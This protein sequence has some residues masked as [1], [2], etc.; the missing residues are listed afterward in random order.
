VRGAR[1]DQRRHRHGSTR[2]QLTINIF[3]TGPRFARHSQASNSALLGDL[4]EA[5]VEIDKLKDALVSNNALPSDPDSEEKQPDLRVGDLVTV[6]DTLKTKT[7]YA[8]LQRDDCV[9]V[10]KKNP[11]S[12]NVSH[13]KGGEPLL[14]RAK[15]PK[16]FKLLER[17]KEEVEEDNPP[18]HWLDLKQPF[19]L[20]TFTAE[21]LREVPVREVPVP[22]V[23]RGGVT[24]NDNT[25]YT[26]RQ[27]KILL[28]DWRKVFPKKK[29]M[30]LKSYKEKRLKELTKWAFQACAKIKVR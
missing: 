3:F 1:S 23:T 11:K 9:Y 4:N 15:G 26:D 29:E 19:P 22:G 7:S 25:K 16:L 27:F 17:E 13:S 24:W 5:N 6:K 20:S 12:V 2:R 28:D 8:D 21:S 14:E 18:T 30:E 10:V